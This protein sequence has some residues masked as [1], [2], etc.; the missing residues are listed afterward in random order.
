[1]VSLDQG[2]PLGLPPSLDPFALVF[3]Q[4]SLAFPPNATRRC[5][6]IPQHMTSIRFQAMPSSACPESSPPS[7]SQHPSPGGIRR[8]R[9]ACTRCRSVHVP[10]Q[11]SPVLHLQ[12][13]L[14]S[15]SCQPCSLIPPSSSQRKTKCSGDRP[16]CV[17]CTRVNRSCHYESYS[18][19]MA[20]MA[21]NPLANSLA[22]FP[23]GFG[24][25]RTF[26]P[27]SL[28]MLTVSVADGPVTAPQHRRGSIGA[29][30]R[31]G[32]ARSQVTS[33]FTP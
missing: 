15:V 33:N 21:G 23:P 1:M 8:I 11:S 14:R 32:I 30:E 12:R 22:N 24:D 17:N 19:T 5:D 2:A 4:L 10:S 6:P 18:S 25:V 16:R 7:R 20:A 31:P 26:P 3:T 9:Q 29:A 27:H 28:W 13:A